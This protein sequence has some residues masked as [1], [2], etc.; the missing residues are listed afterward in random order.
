MATLEGREMSDRKPPPGSGSKASALREQEV[1][2][3]KELRSGNVVYFQDEER[4]E[5]I[6]GSHKQE[7]HLSR[8]P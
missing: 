2:T 4:V 6:R 7:A 8:L 1:C 3:A 5:L